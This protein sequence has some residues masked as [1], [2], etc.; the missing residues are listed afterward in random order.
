MTIADAIWLATA[1]LHRNDP[2][3]VDFAVHDII[4][5]AAQEKFVA[6]FKPGLQVHASKHCVANKSPNPGRSRMLFETTR[7]RRRLFRMG[8][9]F[10]PDRHHGKIRPEKGDLP[11]E[12]QSLLDWY[13]RVYSTQATVSANV[14]PMPL[15]EDA[16]RAVHTTTSY[17]SQFVPGTAFVSA[18]GAVV[19][20]SDLRKELGIEEGTRISVYR[21]QDHLVLQPITDEYIH[22]LVGCLKGEDSLVAA[23]EREHRIEKDRTAR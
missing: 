23:R 14:K 21:E 6:G 8:D 4:Q 13:D 16:F 2:Q 22:S 10:H 7:G 11:P 18:T 5:K 12:Y 17:G 20:P 15:Q 19:I 9:S 1:L 3:A